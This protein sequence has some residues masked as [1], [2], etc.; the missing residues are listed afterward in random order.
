VDKEE[1]ARKIKTHEDK[2]AIPPDWQVIVLA[3]NRTS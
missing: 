1:E 2:D 3:D